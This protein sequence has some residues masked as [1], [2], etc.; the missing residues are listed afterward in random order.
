M[1]AIEIAVHMLPLR[2]SWRKRK[3]GTQNQTLVSLKVGDQLCY[4]N[5][6]P[7]PLS[8]YVFSYNLEMDEQSLIGRLLRI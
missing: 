1:S 7:D 6:V 4:L 2:H 8:L 3:C 5:Q